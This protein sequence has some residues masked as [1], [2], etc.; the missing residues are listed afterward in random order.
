MKTYETFEELLDA[1]RRG[2]IPEGS[3]IEL[4]NDCAFL[5]IGDDCVWRT[6]GDYLPDMVNDLLCM[7]TG[8]VAERC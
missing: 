1:S 4:D 5:Y 7:F 3:R 8:L 2:E 6:Q